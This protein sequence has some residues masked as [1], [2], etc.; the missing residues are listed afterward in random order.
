MNEVFDQARAQIEAGG[1]ELRQTTPDERADA[2]GTKSQTHQRTVA[3]RELANR[4]I[5]A[6]R[7]LTIEELRELL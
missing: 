5:E 3:E 7:P 1:G 4:T 6:T 2:S